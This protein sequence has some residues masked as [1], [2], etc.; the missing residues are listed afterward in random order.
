[1]GLGIVWKAIVGKHSSS[2]CLQMQ[3]KT[4][5]AEPIYQ[6]PPETQLTSPSLSSSEMD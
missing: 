2:I 6:Q 1:M 4:C 3:V 5:E